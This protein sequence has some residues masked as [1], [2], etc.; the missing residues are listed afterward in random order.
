MEQITVEELKK[1]FQDN[2]NLHIIDVREV[3][4]YEEFN[5]GATFLPLSDLRNME[6]DAI[7]DWDEE[8]PIIVHC[9]SGQRSMQACL[10]LETMGYAHAI[11]L[12]GGILAWKE[13]YGSEKLK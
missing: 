2:E 9:E 6:I 7:E 11:V 13:H 10:L 4:E 5:I 1:R 3:E 8:E 12:Q